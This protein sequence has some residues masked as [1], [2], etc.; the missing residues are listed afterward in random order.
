MI[1][2]G[3]CIENMIKGNHRLVY[4]LNLLNEIICSHSRINGF[5]TTLSGCG[6]NAT[7]NSYCTTNSLEPHDILS[8]SETSNL[9][10]AF[11]TESL[12]LED[13]KYFQIKDEPQD[14]FEHKDSICSIIG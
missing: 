1:Q 9:N 13:N 4:I 3:I 6:K 7:L 5:V 14:D 10:S 12:G 11:D 2:I 8:E